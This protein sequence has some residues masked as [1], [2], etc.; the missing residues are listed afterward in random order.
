MAT[1]DI[2]ATVEALVAVRDTMPGD[3]ECERT[4]RLLGVAVGLRPASETVI[5]M[6]HALRVAYGAQRVDVA[7]VVDDGTV[8]FSTAAKQAVVIPHALPDGETTAH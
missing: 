7:I 2:D 1:F 4:A 8:A 3:N 6:V 5:A